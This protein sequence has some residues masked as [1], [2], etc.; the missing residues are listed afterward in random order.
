VNVGG[1]L[2]WVLAASLCV[3][4]FA[5]AQTAPA[6]LGTFQRR[7]SA[8]GAKNRVLNQ[9]EIGTRLFWDGNVAEAATAFEDATVS[10]EFIY[11]QN[12]AATRARSLWYSESE[13]S[14][15]GEPYERA[16]CFYYRG[17]IFLRKGDY[18]NARAAFRQGQLQDAFAEEEQNQ[19]DFALLMFLE[20][21]AS[22][23]N[24]DDDLRDEVLV[25]LKK[26][27]PTFPDIKADDDTLLLFETGT[28]PRKLGD[29]T[30]HAY[31]V[32]RRGRG[33]QENSAQ[34]IVGET[35]IA[36]IPIEDIYYQAS[37]RGG[38]A[39]DKVNAGKANFR[40]ATDSVGSALASTS[41]AIADQ[42]GYGASELNGVATGAALFAGASMLLASRTNARADTRYWASL[43][44]TI[45]I[46]T[47]SSKRSS[48]DG[49]VVRYLANGAPSD[50]ADKPIVPILD[51]NGKRNFWQRS[52]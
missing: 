24:N 5:Q 13:K 20:A 22:H 25:R 6:D 17:L 35:A 43:P 1:K 15:K 49:A 3:A 11:G 36:T 44:D 40:N 41:V 9:M 37:T 7:L 21:W 14:F 33:F 50:I 10:I 23:L 12:E 29:G 39:I 31:F 52:R 27:R 2:F 8:E 42:A 32:L 4:P 18:E 46:A 45:H 48:F 47:A 16:M 34:L 26:I 28:S 38:R 30:N 51:P 19:S